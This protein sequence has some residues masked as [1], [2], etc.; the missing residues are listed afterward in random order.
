VADPQ[1]QNDSNGSH[2]GPRGLPAQSALVLQPP[3]SPVV[4][5]QIGWSVLAGKGMAVQSALVAQA[6]MHVLVPGALGEQAR[7]AGQSVLVTQPHVDATPG[8]G[9]WTLWHTLPPA[10][11]VQLAFVVQPQVFV[12]V[13]QTD[14]LP[15]AAQP[16]FE[17][18]PQ[19]F[20]VVLHTLPWGLVVQSTLVTQPTQSP[21]DVS[22]VG[23]P[24][25]LRGPLWLLQSAF[26]AQAAMHCCAPPGPAGPT[27]GQTKP[28]GQS[29][30][31]AQP[32]TK[33]EPGG[34]RASHI[35]PPA[36]LVQSEFV[37]HPQLSLLQMGPLELLEQS[38]FARHATQLWT[39]VSQSGTGLPQSALVTQPTHTAVCMSQTSPMLLQS[40]LV[41]HLGTHWPLA[42]LQACWLEQSLLVAHP[43]VL[44]IVSQDVPAMLPAQ[45]ALVTHPTH[46][47]V[48][49]LHADPFGFPAQSELDAQAWRH[50]PPMPGG[51]GGPMGGAPLEEHASPAGQFA[52][53]M[54]PHVPV[55]PGGPW[56]LQTLP[57]VLFAQSAAEL[58][59][60][61]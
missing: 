40:A 60:H 2:T 30:L 6:G 49:A 29:V 8:I 22:Q 10:P 23:A 12:V 35:L 56:L 39:V 7:P 54:Q 46:R 16:V 47:P 61:V 4:L 48:A 15:L 27:G 13:L 17:V 31:A 55:E 57:P 14:P 19:V 37:A 34:P 32:H 21:V 45:S 18:Q 58:H 51:P 43:H 26:V 53:V 28:I 42:V 25:W 33:G 1:P 44:V 9:G 38:L 41:L 3:H 59:P 52:F 11:L 24:P 50:E 5:L 36:A 20:V